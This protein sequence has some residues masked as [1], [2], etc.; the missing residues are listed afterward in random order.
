MGLVDKAV[1]AAIGDGI[2]L[3]ASK[4]VDSMIGPDVSLVMAEKVFPVFLEFAKIKGAWVLEASKRMPIPDNAFIRRP[5][6]AATDQ[7]IFIFIK[8]MNKYQETKI[9]KKWE[10]FLFHMKREF[11]LMMNQD[12]NGLKDNQF[13]KDGFERFIYKMQTLK[14]RIEFQNRNKMISFILNHF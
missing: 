1:D 5:L 8:K 10:E 4:V 2:Q 6:D 11:T 14:M 3:S 9:D 12:E 13:I 7:A